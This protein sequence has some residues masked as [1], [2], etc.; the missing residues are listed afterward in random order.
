MI[1]LRV[2]YVFNALDIICFVMIRR[3]SRSTQ[4]RSSAASDVYK[5]QVKNGLSSEYIRCGMWRWK[6]LPPKMRELA[7]EMGISLPDKPEIEH[8]STGA[9]RR[10][11]TGRTDSRS[12]AGS[13]SRK[14]GSGEK[15]P[16]RSWSTLRARDSSV[17]D[18]K[19]GM[20]R[21]GERKKRKE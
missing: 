19:R 13:I 21:P 20:K 14:A 16:L 17:P 11:R 10:D 2:K 8:V 18:P 12:L 15:A 3:P 5:R 1:A 7:R 4:G 6:S 9:G